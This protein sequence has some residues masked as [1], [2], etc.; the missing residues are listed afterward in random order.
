MVRWPQTAP[1]AEEGGRLF[2][3]NAGVRAWPPP[4]IPFFPHQSPVLTRQGSSRLPALGFLP[5]HV[6]L[7]C[8][9]FTLTTPILTVSNPRT[10]SIDRFLYI[11]GKR[12]SF[13][14]LGAGYLPYIVPSDI[15]NHDS[16]CHS[17]EHQDGPRRWTG[18]A[19][20][21]AT[22]GTYFQTTCNI[23]QKV[24][25]FPLMKI[26]TEKPACCVHWMSNLN[27]KAQG[28]RLTSLSIS[29]PEDQPAKVPCLQEAPVYSSAA[30]TFQAHRRPC[31]LL[32][33]QLHTEPKIFIQPLCL[34]THRE[35][36]TRNGT[37]GGESVVS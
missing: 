30:P 15:I 18:C 14:R 6:K 1:G 37:W 3:L 35:M 11:D 24:D 19:Q 32:S 28:C 7:G 26:I 16:L 4:C 23:L 5:S 21:F 20:F 27:A 10:I 31:C 22:K 12:A 13:Q 29:S 36:G 2:L 33:P 8:C 9:A 17:P 25:F 34:N